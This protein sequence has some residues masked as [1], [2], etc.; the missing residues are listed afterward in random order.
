MRSDYRQGMGHGGDSGIAVE[1]FEVLPLCLAPVDDGVRTRRPVVGLRSYLHVDVVQHRPN[2]S[3][4]GIELL[5]LG[6]RLQ[7]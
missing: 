3:Q 7:L 1:A 2:S 4:H 6:L 5:P